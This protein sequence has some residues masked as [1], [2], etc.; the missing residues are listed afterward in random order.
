MIEGGCA[1]ITSGRVIER[2]RVT[3]FREEIQ[4]KGTDL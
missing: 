4:E 2:R 3:I 1:S